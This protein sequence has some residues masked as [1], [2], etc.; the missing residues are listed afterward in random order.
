MFLKIFIFINEKENNFIFKNLITLKCKYHL[1]IL[2]AKLNNFEVQILLFTH[3]ICN[4]FYIFP[5]MYFVIF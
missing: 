2:L 4:S 1:H 3:F 5:L